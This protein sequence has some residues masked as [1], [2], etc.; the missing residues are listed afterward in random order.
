MLYVK[1]TSSALS[2]IN[3]NKITDLYI[4]PLKRRVCCR[5]YMDVDILKK[6]SGSIKD[7]EKVVHDGITFHIFPN[8]RLKDNVLSIDC[9]KFM[10]IEKLFVNSYEYDFGFEVSQE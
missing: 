10:L 2:Y 7:F 4:E 9:G 3:K 8:I 5:T 1:L 6:P